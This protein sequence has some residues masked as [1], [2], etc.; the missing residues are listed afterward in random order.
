ML[1][2]PAF[3]DLVGRWATETLRTEAERLACT[4]DNDQDTDCDPGD[5]LLIALA[6]LEVAATRLW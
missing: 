1:M 5:P 2:D 3:P 4:N 6:K